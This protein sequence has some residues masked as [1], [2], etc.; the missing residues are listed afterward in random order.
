[1][2]VT[3]T[4][5]SVF[6]G[7]KRVVEEVVEAEVGDSCILPPLKKTAVSNQSTLV[8]SARTKSQVSLPGEFENKYYYTVE[9][10]ISNSL[11]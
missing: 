11:R 7:K 4:S 6:G 5:R 10:F 2:I 9:P 3:N 1:M 8:S